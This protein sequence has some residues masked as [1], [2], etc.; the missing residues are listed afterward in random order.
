M[1]LPELSRELTL[2]PD[3][4]RNLVTRG[5]VLLRDEGY[6]LESFSRL[7]DALCQRL[8]FDPARQHVSQQA[9]K[10]DAGNGAVGLH[11][12]NGNTPLP[13]DIVAFHS[14]LSASRGAQT[15]WCDGA[16]VCRSLPRELRAVFSQPITVTRYLPKWAWQRYVANAFGIGEPEAVTHEQ[17]QQFVDAV[18]R[19]KISPAEQEGVQYSLT[20]D[21]IRD[22]NLLGVAAFANALLGPSYNYQAPEYR[23]ADGGLVDAAMLREL[24]EICEAHTSEIVWQDG[25]V[26]LLDNKRIMHGRR[27]IPVPLDERRLYIGM[28]SG[29]K[30]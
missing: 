15:T 14:E 23:F 21:P 11:I 27:S 10:V 17:L 1:A 7:M 4:K 30:Y 2:L 29:L 3:I 24:S 16:L 6:N 19:Q 13:P 8:T 26:L 9:Q 22:D 28:G 5:W 25:D 12:E 20:F 18:P